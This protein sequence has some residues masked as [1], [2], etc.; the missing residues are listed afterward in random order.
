MTSS[1]VK[2]ICAIAY[3]IACVI[4]SIIV[5]HYFEESAQEQINQARIEAATTKVALQTVSSE[6]DKLR[7]MMSRANEAVERV[8]D[9]IEKTQRDHDERI[10]TIHDDPSASDWLVCDLPDS[11]RNAFGDYCK[12]DSR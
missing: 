4:I 2:L 12:D 9:V 1:T 8:I 7:E 6:N 10:Q 3:A 11:V 5:I